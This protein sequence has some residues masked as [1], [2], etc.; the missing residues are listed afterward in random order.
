VQTECKE[1]ILCRGAARSHFPNAK[2][3]IY[4]ETAKFFSSKFHILVDLY[5]E[6]VYCTPLLTIDFLHVMEKPL[7]FA[8]CFS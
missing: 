7:T 5:Q 2:V 3:G 6:S 1:L 4:F 8:S